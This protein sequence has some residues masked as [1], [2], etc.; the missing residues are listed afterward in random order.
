MDV[1][2]EFYCALQNKMYFCKELLYELVPNV[3]TCV[4][5]GLDFS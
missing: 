3:L 4:L 2:M 1:M 5:R